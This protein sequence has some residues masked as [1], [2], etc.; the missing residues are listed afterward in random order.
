MLRRDKKEIDCNKGKWIGVGGK[1]LENESPDDC[2][3]RETL[4][5]TGLTLNSV[6]LRGIIKFESDEYEDELIYLYTSDDFSGELTD[7]CPEGTLRWI[8][9][10]DILSLELWE[11][12]RIFLKELLDGDRDILLTLSYKGDRLVS[13]KKGC[14]LCPRECFADRVNNQTGLCHAGKDTYIAR[15]ALHMWEEPVFSGKKGA[16][17]VFFSGCNMACVYCQNNKISKKLFGKKVDD[18]ELAAEFLKLQD[19]GANNIDL[20][21]PGHYTLSVYRALKTARKNGLKIPVLYNCGGYESVYSLILMRGLVDI[22]MP[23]FKYMSCEAAGRYSKTPDYPDIAKAAISEMFSQ[24]GKFRI[25][26]DGIMTSGV[27]VRHLVLPGHADDSK[28]IIKYLYETYKDDI[29][30]SIMSQYTVVSDLSDY[31]EI[32]RSVYP[33]EYRKVVDYAES[34][35]IENAFIQGSDVDKE[36]FIPDFYG[37]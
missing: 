37:D 19:M 3:L 8:K 12:D 16:G 28:R 23:D 36:S 27:L 31:P 17:T 4:E 15:A 10:E 7:D 32:N 35:G 21:T 6:T 33:W 26:E 18:N 25:N 14:F 13:V 34:L 29:Y 30:L 20:V 9:K 22:Y 2:V 11:G 1:L 24:R 5:E